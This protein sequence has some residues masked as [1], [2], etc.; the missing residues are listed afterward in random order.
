MIRHGYGFGDH[1]NNR[2]LVFPNVINDPK[3]IKLLL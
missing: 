1:N 2:E 3:H